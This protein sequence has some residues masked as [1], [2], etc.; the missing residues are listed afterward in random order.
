MEKQDMGF[1]TMSPGVPEG[2][3]EV[4]LSERDFELFIGAFTPA[5]LATLR[6]YA[7]F[8]VNARRNGLSVKYDDACGDGSY[9]V[10]GPARALKLAIEEARERNIKIRGE[11]S[12]DHRSDDAEMSFY[13]YPVGENFC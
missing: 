8:M 3:V 5:H 6:N 13:L 7:E 9:D 12:F 10:V 2:A 1:V 4:K 11:P